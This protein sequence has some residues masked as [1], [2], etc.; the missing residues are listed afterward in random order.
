MVHSEVKQ[1]AF[2]KKELLERD[3]LFKKKF[4]YAKTMPYDTLTLQQVQLVP[5][6]RILEELKT[7][8]E[9]MKNMIYGPKPTFDEIIECLKNLEKEIH[10]L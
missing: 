5:E 2:A 10:Q 9:A 1:M 4:Y 7:D 3:V 6:D 8:Y